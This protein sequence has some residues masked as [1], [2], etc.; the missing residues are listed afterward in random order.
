MVRIHDGLLLSHKNESESVLVWWMTLVPL[1]EWSKTEG[2]KQVLH[3]NAYVWNLGKMVLTD[4]V[5]NGHAD[6]AG[7]EDDG[8]NWEVRTDMYTLPRAKRMASGNLLCN[9]GS[10]APCFVV[11]ERV[12]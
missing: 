2:E 7:V 10:S 11:T 9:T 6:T 8:M 5:E 12:G 3:I 4:P 1:I